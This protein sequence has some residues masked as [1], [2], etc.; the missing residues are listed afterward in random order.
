MRAGSYWRPCANWLEWGVLVVDNGST[1]RSVEVASAAGARVEVC[2]QRVYG[3]A[4]RHGSLAANG[5]WIVMADAGV[6]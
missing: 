2:T 3:A 1:D 4:L 6:R 5:Q